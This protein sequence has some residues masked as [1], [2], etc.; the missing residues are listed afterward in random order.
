MIRRGP[1]AGALLAIVAVLG[2]ADGRA[3]PGIGRLELDPHHTVVA[4]HLATRLHDV[5]GTFQL[6]AGTLA[7]DPASGAARGDIVVDAASG[8]SGNG[9]RDSR[10]TSAVLEAAQFPEIRFRPSRV[11]GK[12]RSDGTFHAVLHGWLTLHGSEHAIA[13]AVDGRLD[14]DQL[15]AR[16][17]FT[18][19][20]LEWG[21]ADPSVLLLTVGKT[22]DVDVTTA[23]RVVWTSTLEDH[24]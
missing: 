21:L 7:V 13:V 4:F 2:A 24:P 17:R 8:E 22:V 5:D 11:D 15:N 3:E 20:Y 12:P 14:G 16:G 10:M 9:S 19:P 1:R 18:V 6:R 23:G